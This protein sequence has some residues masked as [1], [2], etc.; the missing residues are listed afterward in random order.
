MCFLVSFAA[1]RQQTRGDTMNFRNHFTVSIGAGIATSVALAGSASAALT[2]VSAI[3]LIA[4]MAGGTLPD[5]DHKSSKIGRSL[6][7]FS[8][9][10]ST[11][12]EHRGLTHSVI[13]IIGIWFLLKW[14]GAS[15]ITSF[16][17]P[18]ESA[19][20]FHIFTI[21]FCS[22]ILSHALADACT[23]A[24]VRLFYPLNYRF[25]FPIISWIS[26]SSGSKFES[27]S[28][29][30]LIASFVGSAIAFNRYM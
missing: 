11:L 1:Q 26:L 15:A 27:L 12:F 20:Y 21:G 24:G 18:S 13:F 6:K 28:A 23:K 3:V 16:G 25:R 29:A 10:I 9:I 4:A 8:S 7:I 17:L 14:L 5:I 19:Y 2:P 22:G 30:L